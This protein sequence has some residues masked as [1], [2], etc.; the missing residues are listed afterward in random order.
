MSVKNGSNGKLELSRGRETC[1]RGTGYCIYANE[2]HESV[3]H[4][5]ADPIQL[6]LVVPLHKVIVLAFSRS[7]GFKLTLAFK[8]D[9]LESLNVSSSF[10]SI[11]VI[12]QFIQT[13][14]LQY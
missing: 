1:D 9:P 7:D 4:G 14:S 2:C 10:D 3:I 8:D 12:N 13:V 6:V 11:S 5:I